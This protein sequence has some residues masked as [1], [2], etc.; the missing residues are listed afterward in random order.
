[1]PSLP[2]PWSVWSLV[3]DSL[4]SWATWGWPTW[5][6]QWSRG[7]VVPVLWWHFLLYF[8]NLIPF[9]TKVRGCQVTSRGNVIHIQPGPWFPVTWHC[10][11]CQHKQSGRQAL[12]RTRMNG[13]QNF[14]FTLSDVLWS[15]ASLG[16]KMFLAPRR[17]QDGK[18]RN[19]RSCNRESR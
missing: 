11:W 5:N 4:L 6:R 2:K 9:L 16:K 17:R 15:G 14:E 1:M 13:G 10:V 8:W 3:L 18:F 19:N 12:W 7:R